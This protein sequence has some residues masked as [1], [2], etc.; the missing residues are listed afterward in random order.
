MIPLAHMQKAAADGLAFLR[1]QQDIEEAEVFVASN[2]VLLARLNYTSHIPCNGVE[3]PKSTFNYGIGVQAVF[4]PGG[5]APARAAGGGQTGGPP[6]IRRIGFGSETSDITLDGVRSALDKARKGASADPEFVSLPRPGGEQRKLKGYHDPKLMEIKDA[7]LVD[8]GWRVVNGGLRVFQTSEALT[9][10]VGSPDHLRPLGLIISGDVTILQERIAVASSAMPEVQTDESTLIMSFI[11]SMVEREGAKGSGY[12][13]STTLAGFTEEAGREAAQAAIAGIGG[14][15]VPSGEY[16]VV[17]GR[18][19]AMEIL[20][21]IIMPGLSTGVFYAS[22]SPFMGQLGKQVASRKFTLIDDGG[23]AG[24]VGAKG[25]TC[26]G[27]ATGRT[28]LIKDGVLVGL[29]SNHYESQRLQHDPKAKEKLGADPKDFPR[30]FV[31]RNGFRFARGG[32]RHFD[33]QPGI[34][35]TNVIVPGTVESTEAMCKLVGDGLYIGRIWYTY[36]VN[37]LR[38][39][40]FTGTVVADSYVI[41]DG[42]IA[43]PLRANSLRI[44]ENIRDVLNGV[45]G[46]SKEGKPTL[47]WAADEIVYAPEIAVAKVRMDAIGEYME[48]L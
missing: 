10:L 48:S 6:E 24:L 11:T 33:A 4:R 27:L 37:G 38:A 41:R 40:D 8:A 25:I 12:A 5:R 26:E 1:S 18:E 19:A 15:R 46:V 43:E 39:G 28:E 17:F 34:N 42:K 23:A 32:G 22:G 47:V 3:E 31:P 44:N 9:D 29:L 20:H 45:I 14:V 35:P 2:G 30:A 7:D 21:Y 16:K 13:A 36:P